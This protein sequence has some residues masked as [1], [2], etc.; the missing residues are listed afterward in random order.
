MASIP[1]SRH[2]AVDEGQDALVV[3]DRR[4]VAP[5]LA[6]LPFLATALGLFYLIGVVVASH[7]RAGTIGVPGGYLPIVAILA[8]AGAVFLWPGMH[9]CVRNHS[10]RIN[11]A[12]RT[13]DDR[14]NWLIYTHVKTSRFD[15]FRDVSLQRNIRT[16]RT[17]SDG[18]TTSG[19]HHSLSVDLRF[20][21]SAKKNVRLAFDYE[22][23]VI[24]PLAQHVAQYTG[25]PLHDDLADAHY[26]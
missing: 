16:S 9:L 15:E 4:R 24:R 20:T 1:T 19:S 7:V 26:E 23:A 3:R 10:V 22:P 6:G 14:V 21:D 2:F 12:E 25:L 5:A 13:V 11:R 17:S 18:Q 8:V